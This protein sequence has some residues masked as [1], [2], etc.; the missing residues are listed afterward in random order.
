MARGFFGA[1]PDEMEV[2]E[3]AHW[4]RENLPRRIAISA[5]T[6]SRVTVSSIGSALLPL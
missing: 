5:S 4:Y 2:R 1:V 6:E 3:K